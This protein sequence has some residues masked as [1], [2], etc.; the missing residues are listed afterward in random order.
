MA[1]R[2]EHS[3]SL[4]MLILY[5]FGV[6]SAPL[7]AALVYGAVHMGRLADQSKE[8]VH[9]AVRATEHANRVTGQSTTMERIGRQYLLCKMRAFTP[10]S[11]RPMTAF[12][13]P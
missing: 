3:K 2:I 12:E 5:G 10:P 8:A 11:D 9:Q 13:P 1:F 7:I 6:V 4:P